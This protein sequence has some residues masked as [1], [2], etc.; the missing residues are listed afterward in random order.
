MFINSLLLEVFFALF[1]IV[2]ITVPNR[3]KNII[4][5]ADSYTFYC[6]NGYKNAIVVFLITLITY[7][8]AAC[9]NRWEAYMRIFLSVG[10]VA[11]VGVL[12]TFK[13]FAFW[14]YTWFMPVAISFYSLQAI[15]YLMDLYRGG[16][17]SFEKIL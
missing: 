5:L 8:M 9:M 7:V 16:N 2:Y 4:L 3:F 10:I 13:I 11:V 1:C 6:V 12:G 17:G 14:G 15:G